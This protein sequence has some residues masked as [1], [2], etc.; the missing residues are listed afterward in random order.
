M[1]N[2]LI[3]YTL[4]RDEEPGCVLPTH[5]YRVGFC[6]V[7]QSQICKIVVGGSLEGRLRIWVAKE[8]FSKCT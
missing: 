7:Y 3:P 6:Y 8:T 4:S 1:M 2:Q 5:M